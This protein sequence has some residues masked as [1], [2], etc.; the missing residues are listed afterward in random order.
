MLYSQWIYELPEQ[1]KLIIMLC[2]I[3]SVPI[4]LLINYLCDIIKEKRSNKGNK[5]NGEIKRNN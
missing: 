5:R 1:T 2:M 4:L 3:A